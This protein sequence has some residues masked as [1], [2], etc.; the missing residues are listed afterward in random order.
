MNIIFYNDFITNTFS[1]FSQPFFIMCALPCFFFPS[2]RGFLFV[3]FY[4]V[5]FLLVVHIQNLAF[6]LE[7]VEFLLVVHIQNLAFI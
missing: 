6:Y 5:E 1:Y 2:V 7:L 4:F 3:A